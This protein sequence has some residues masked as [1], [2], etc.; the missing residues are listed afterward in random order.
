MKS[1]SL[2]LYNGMEGLLSNSAILAVL[3]YGGYLVIY[4]QTLTSG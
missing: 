1:L 3:W 4:K 2:G